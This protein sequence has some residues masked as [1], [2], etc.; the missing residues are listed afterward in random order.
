M[1]NTLMDYPQLSNQL[2][3][4]IHGK[5]TVTFRIDCSTREVNSTGLSTEPN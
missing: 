5:Q 1:Y 2:T 4:N 3:V